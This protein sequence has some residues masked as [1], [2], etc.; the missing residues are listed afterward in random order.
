L[1]T[2]KLAGIR[3]VSVEL[4]ISR[5][6]AAEG[7]KASQQLCPSRFTRN[8]ELPGVSDVNLDLIPFLEFKRLDNGGRKTDGETVAPFGDL[9]MAISL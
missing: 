9:H 3:L 8:T 2:K 4:E 5:K 1:E 7:P 6:T